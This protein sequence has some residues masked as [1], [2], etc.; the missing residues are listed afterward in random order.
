MSAE[1]SA[2]SQGSRPSTSAAATSSS[3]VAPKDEQPMKPPRHR[4]KSIQPV[5]TTIDNLDDVNEVSER[6]VD[7]AT[8]R[9]NT[10]HR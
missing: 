9:T 6:C 3:S 8:K 4:P 10:G 5:E 7:M 1:K 2:S